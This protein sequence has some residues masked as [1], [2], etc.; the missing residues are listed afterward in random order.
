MS[1][2]ASAKF[3]IALTLLAVA[4]SRP[5]AQTGSYAQTITIP[6]TY[7]D[8]HSDGSNPE[9]EKT[10]TAGDAAA[11][12]LGMVADTLDKDRKPVLGPNPYWNCYIKKWFRKWEPGDFT[13]PNYTNPATTTC[14]NPI[15]TV[16][17]DTAFKNVVVPGN[18]VFQYQDGT[19]GTYRYENPTFFPLDDVPGTFGSE[20][21]GATPIH[22]YGFSLE[23]HYNFT[24]VKGLTFQFAGDDDCW[25]YINNK[26]VMDIG[27]IHNTKTGTL[28][29]DSLHIP[30]LTQCTFDFFYCERHR[31]GSD[32]EIT[33]NLITALDTG[34]NI[35]ANPKKDTIPAGSTI[36]Y[37]ASVKT[38]F[39][40]D[41]T[42]TVKKVAWLLA[43]SVATPVS[44][45]TISADIGKKT[46]FKGIT[47][48]YDAKGDLLPY[49]VSATLPNPKNPLKPLVA[50]VVV[51]VKPG[52]AYKLIIVRDT[53]LSKLF[54]PVR[55]GLVSM[56]SATNYDTVFAVTYDQYNNYSGLGKYFGFAS[57][58]VWATRDTN[59]VTVKPGSP[60]TGII[61]RETRLPVSTIV[62]VSQGY[63]LPDSVNVTLQPGNPIAIRL[64]NELGVPVTKDSMNTDQQSTLKIQVVWSNA[65]GVWVDAT[66]TWAIS[67][68]TIRWDNSLPTGLAGTW[69]LSPQ[70]PGRENLTVK[71]GNIPLTIPIIVTPAP[72]SR[73][74]IELANPKDSIIAGR[75][76]K[77]VVKIYNLDGLYPDPWCSQSATY[78]DV[79]GNGN[80]TVIPFIM[81]NGNPTPVPLGTPTGEC[82][83]KGVDTVSVVLY[84]A[85]VSIDSTHQ[86]SLLLNNNITNLALVSTLPFHLYPGPL[87]A[88]RLEY[89]TGRDMPGPDTLYYPN[90]SVNIYARGYDQFGNLI[91]D[92]RSDW[93]K[94]GSLPSFSPP[95]TKQVN[96]FIESGAAVLNENG[97]VI[98]AAP[99]G[100]LPGSNVSDTV[101]VIII[102]R[103]ANLA[104]ATTKDMNGNGY[105]DQIEVKF[106]KP[107][108]ASSSAGSII[109][110]DIDHSVVF[111]VDSLRPKGSS[112]DSTSTFIIYLHDI[113]STQNGILEPDGAIP[114][115]SWRPLL[116][117]SGLKGANDFNDKKCKDGAGPVV[118]KVLCFKNSAKDRTKDKVTVTFSEPILASTGNDFS[119]N[120]APSLVFSTWK[121]DGNL[122]VADTNLL[123][124]NIDLNYSTAACI[125]VFSKIVDSNTVEFDMLNQKTL[126]DYDFFSIRMLPAA[127]VSDK[128]NPANLP[129]ASN[130]RVRVDVVGA[131]SPMKIGPNPATPTFFNVPDAN[132]NPSVIVFKNEPNA[133]HY[134]KDK[135]G[136]VLRFYI[137]P[138]K[139][140][141]TAYLNIYD[142]IGNV[143]NSVHRDGPTDDIM[144]EIRNTY[145]G[146]KL[147][148]ASNY[149]Y[150]I[151]WNGVNA[152]GM[153]TAPGV[154]HAFLY[155]TTYYPDGTIVKTRQQGIIGIARLQ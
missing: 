146:A 86:I 36:E 38:D 49:Y 102:P 25:A 90:G 35:D 104:E 110:R 111:T 46:I 84:N 117:I 85:P 142:V 14:S 129:V 137:S 74:T 95:G 54:T 89:Q 99:S 144:A 87:A 6:V 72:P 1:K 96:V 108:P 149:T 114:Q 153:K 103:Q 136:T 78:T 50:T 29:V 67:P 60:F 39:G 126:F 55:L 57:A 123:S 7:Y 154:Y 92:I 5:N 11:P 2:F 43:P 45:S 32:I 121:R 68:D 65:P 105:L 125:A 82:F 19:A 23:L 71:S 41:D 145:N 122:L 77:V 62:Q 51:Y 28:Y 73:A 37:T 147:D 17:Y 106:D 21:A 81:V 120:I 22:N 150:D 64:V 124:C 130:Q 140:R 97:Q 112:R 61:H 30:D 131:I 128:A 116:S 3:L 33:T 135:G 66:G 83:V 113:D 48:L 155:S 148:T 132:G 18:L 9:F 115:T 53:T 52:P 118:W 91:G 141:I 70:N 134:A 93:S 13:I 10:P 143:V 101:Q 47:A 107:I 119:I 34:I 80:K 4:F 94:I 20:P 151:Y 133:T 139:G 12:K 16:N 75:P 40:I 58:A 69:I 138:G 56:D 24:M 26:L 79:I 8:F 100:V 15:A 59:V 88:L 42:V 98:A 152:R 44:Q 127:Q 27:G 63:L 76:F 109:I 31:T